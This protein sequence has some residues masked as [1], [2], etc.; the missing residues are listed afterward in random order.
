MYYDFIINNI[1][2][3]RTIPFQSPSEVLEFAESQNA[4]HVRQSHRDY[5]SHIQ[6]IIGEHGDWMDI[7]TFESAVFEFKQNRR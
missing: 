4:S 6:D 2:F 1:R 5:P 7:P 3:E